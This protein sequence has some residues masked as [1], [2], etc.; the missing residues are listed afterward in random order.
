MTDPTRG[1]WT[2]A[3][4]SALALVGVG[5]LARLGASPATVALSVAGAAIPWAWFA[6]HEPE[7]LPTRPLLVLLLLAGGAQLLVPPQLSDDVYRYLWDGHV[8]LSGI[9]PYR[10]APDDPALAALRPAGTWPAEVWGRVNHPDIPTIY[11]PVAQG[12]FVLGAVLAG[13]LVPL[14]IGAAFGLQLFGLLAHLL[15]GFA[16]GRLATALGQPAARARARYWLFPPALVEAAQG[17]HA[18]VYAGLALTLALLALSRGRLAKVVLASLMATGTKLVGLLVLP[19]LAPRFPQPAH[20]P[21]RRVVALLAL[22]LGSFLLVWPLLGAGYGS[23]RAG[24][25]SNYA[26]RWRGND[27]LYGAL[28]AGA[29]G[30]VMALAEDQPDFDPGLAR[31]GIVVLPSLRPLFRGRS[32]G[33]PL[34]LRAGLDRAKKDQGDPG[35]FPVHVLAAPIARGAGAGLLGVLLLVLVWR[36]SPPVRAFR[37]LLYAALLVAPQVHPWYLLWLLPIE[38]SLGKHSAFVLSIG[39]V[40]AYAPLDLWTAARIWQE[41]RTAVLFAY[42]ASGLVF[43]VETWASQHANQAK[44]DAIASPSVDP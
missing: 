29:S 21:E 12:V 33:G 37:L 32:D 30:L 17:A 24:G 16:V 35:R 23:G 42:G 18:D 7:R 1:A 20:R 27:G 28:E 2:S 10:F 39:L 22:V 40:C 11:P 14:G 25:F 3:S 31:E 9:D 8:A 34:H 15:L 13:W 38:A 19:F 6:L 41:P 4:A 26:R 5:L 43:A 36:R 44:G